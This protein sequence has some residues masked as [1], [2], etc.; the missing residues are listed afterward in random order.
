MAWLTQRLAHQE[1]RNREAYIRSG[2]VFEDRQQ[3]FERRTQELER[4]MDAAKSLSELL[5][6]KMPE[7][8]EASKEPGAR[9]GVNLDA[10]SV[11]AEMGAKIEQEL[12]SGQSPWEDEETRFFY[13]DLCDLRAHVPPALLKEASAPNAAEPAEDAENG[14]VPAQVNALF[15]RLPNLG[16]RQMI[17]EAAVELA[18]CNTRATRNR[19]VRHLLSVPRERRDLLPYYAR[20][21]ATLHPYMADVSQ[22]VLH[23]LDSEFR[24]LQRRRSNDAGTAQSR[25]RNAVFLGEL[26]K[27]ALV[28][29]HQLFYSLKTLV[30]DFSVPA[31][32]VLATFLETC[33]RYLV[34]TPATAERMHGV[35]QVLQRKRQA[36]HTDSRVALLL[37]NAY[38][39]CVPP[40]RVAIAREAPTV[41]QQFIT[42]LFCQLLAKN[43]VDRVVHLVRRLD[44]EQ[45]DVRAAL[46]ARFTRPW[47]LK[48]HLVHLL[49]QIM[50]AL[51]PMHTDFFVPVLDNV[52]EAIQ[53]GL[54]QNQFQANQRRVALVHY[55][56][57]LYNYRV[58]NSHVIMDFLANCCH[59]RGP[60]GATDY[61]RV[62]LVCTMLDTCGACFDT[63]LARK[64]MD[65][66]LLAFQAYVGRK[67][68]PLPADTAYRLKTTLETLRPKLVWRDEDQEEVERRV[69]G[70]LPFYERRQLASVA[71][72]AASESDDESDE[73]DDESAGDGPRRPPPEREPE[74]EEP[75]ESAEDIEARERER[76]EELEREAELALDQ[77]LAQ[78]MGESS[79]GTGGTPAAPPALSGLPQHGLFAR[80]E[81]RAD[82]S[83]DYMVFSLLSRRGNRAQTQE[84]HVPSD[85]A[86]SVH[87][88]Q[89]LE[90]EA[91]ER[92]QLKAYVLAYRDREELE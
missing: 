43:N 18:F 56:G 16:S 36:H 61:F 54:E 62:T 24:Q 13:T 60:D 76:E 12:A 41:M 22:G 86:M 64:R 2:E 47:E 4:L 28:P 89:Q 27:F 35:L 17:D 38:Y 30:D 83:E 90:E 78:L 19:L 5:A 91:N 72:G 32:E 88:R 71:A 7:M 74:A 79:G 59:A 84:V 85:N 14:S 52:A 80:P 69:E 92:R 8:E 55:L 68:K 67:A 65:E 31:L 44:W 70:L 50:R 63:G 45:P 82:A 34:R 23:G 73:S 48:F 20:L 29:E 40:P 26:V 75:V 42:Y 11:L 81:A 49:A 6:V 46:F 9:L 58:V 33:G 21:V 10:K 39:Q 57:E 51:Y 53:E 1:E 87:V 77:E 15:A 25:A 37:D 3:T 66:F